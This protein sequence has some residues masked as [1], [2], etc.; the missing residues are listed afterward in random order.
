[1]ADDQVES[2]SL[3]T[4]EAVPSS[5]VRLFKMAWQLENWL[6]LMVYVELRAARLDWEVPIKENVNQGQKQWP[7][8]SLAKDKELHHMATSHQVALSYLSFAELWKII[9][10]KQNWQLFKSYFPPESIAASRMDE[11][12]TIR[13]RIAHFREPHKN[14]EAR[15]QLFLQDM[16]EGIRRFCSRYTSEVG[17]KNNPVSDLIQKEWQNIGYGYEMIGLD[18]NWLYAPEPYASQP[19]MHARLQAL[20]RE[21]YSSGSI[22]GVIYKLTI[23]PRLNNKLDLRDFLTRTLF[24]HSDVIH[25]I[26]T[27]D[28]QVAVTIPAVHDAE[29]VVFLVAGFL[30]LG[31]A[32]SQSSYAPSLRGVRSEWPE[33]VLWPDH[34][35]A[36]FDESMRWP[37]FHL[38]E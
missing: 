1:V 13:N 25:I 30:R 34:V 23:W 10:D 32:C 11:I 9:S 24:G 12:K 21:D 5:A 20:V 14:D 3:W 16:E 22:E 33:Y 37:L 31:L 27:I 4:Y 35:L 38:P 2:D 19:Q 6:R 28:D 15:F 17:L 8:H 36:C 18:G 26:A 29:T 7:P